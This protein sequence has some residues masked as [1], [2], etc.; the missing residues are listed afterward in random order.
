MRPEIPTGER[1]GKNDFSQLSLD[2]Q[3]VQGSQCRI[4]EF[5]PANWPP[6]AVL[7]S[8]RKSV[9]SGIDNDIISGNVQGYCYVPRAA[10][11]LTSYTSA[12]E[13]IYK[14]TTDLVIKETV[15]ASSALKDTNCIFPSDTSAFGYLK[16]LLSAKIIKLLEG[17]ITS[18]DKLGP[19]ERLHIMMTT[20]TAAGTDDVITTLSLGN[21]I[22]TLDRPGFSV[23]V[24]GSSSQAKGSNV[25]ISQYIF[26]TGKLNKYSTSSAPYYN[27]NL[28]QISE[29]IGTAQGATNTFDQTSS[30]LRVHYNHR[31]NT[32]SGTQFNE[33][34]LIDSTTKRFHSQERLIRLQVK[35]SSAT[36]RVDAATF[37]ETTNK[38]D[39][40]ANTDGAVSSTS[41]T[42]IDVTD[43][44][45]F[46]AADVISIAS[47]TEFML[48]ESISS[49][50]LTV[51][52]GYQ[53]TTAATHSDA[54]N[55]YILAN[56]GKYGDSLDH[57][58]IEHWDRVMYHDY[59]NRPTALKSRGLLMYANNSNATNLGTP[60]QERWS[61]RQ[62]NYQFNYSN[63]SSVTDNDGDTALIFGGTQ[64]QDSDDGGSTPTSPNKTE[65]TYMAGGHLLR[66]TNYLLCCQT[67][68]F[69]KLFMRMSNTIGWRSSAP[70]VLD[71]STLYDNTRMN[72]V[73]WYTAKT[74]KTAS[75]Y[76]WKAMPIVD[77]TATG[78]A[79]T[80]LRKSGT[81]YFEM[82]DDWVQVEASDLPWTAGNNLPV[83][84]DDGTANDPMS[85][86]TEDMY[87]VLLGIAVD[88]A[89]PTAPVN[90]RCNY[91][92]PCNNSHSTIIKIIDPHHKSLND[93]AIAQSISW[94]RKGNYSTSTDRFGRA[95]IRKLGASG[96]AVTFGGVELSG[97][98]TTQK[99]LLNIYQREGTPVY[100]DVQRAVSSGEY[101]RFYGILTEMSED[102]PVGNQHP[103]F[104]LTMQIEYISEFDSNGAPIG[105]YLQSLGGEIIDEPK[106]LL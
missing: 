36:T 31:F 79:N 88:G 39:S 73:A 26:D 61:E 12:V 96:G 29:T 2:L 66:P 41:A 74:D 15:G 38:R 8:D 102:Y 35:D 56:N 43:G 32:R 81:V 21:P 69:N 33:T 23:M 24:D 5:V 53:G 25:S 89:A 72:M 86:W 67:D 7:K 76:E 63:F 37:Y 104:G 10:D 90:I 85:L 57:S 16:E 4:P 59:I 14:T 52:R 77:G 64:H 75:S 11:T 30:N 28:E 105:A 22:Q 44:T 98:Y 40:T 84:G 62:S 20:G 65:L 18:S 49:N 101:I 19:D 42:T 51:S 48:V 9:F 71:D 70:G 27:V 87:G 95:E 60:G 47:G 106:Y 83:D 78:G 1:F 103:K 3:Q 50:E 97:N 34:H 54:Q 99:K 17:T 6:T 91:V 46:S 13:V 100:L 93:I 68:R 45:Q 80:S 58:F 55:V 94:G 92:V 82:P